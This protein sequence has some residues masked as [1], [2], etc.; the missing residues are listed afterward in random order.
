MAVPTHEHIYL[1]LGSI[2][3]FVECSE[4]RRTAGQPQECC[5]ERLDP[6]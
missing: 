3:H 5:Q 2:L 6:F 4:P 1:A